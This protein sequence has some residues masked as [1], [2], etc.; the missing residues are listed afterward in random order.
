M[1]S[2]TTPLHDDDAV[3]VDLEADTA[4]EPLRERGH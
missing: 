3:A 1:S 2:M 4:G